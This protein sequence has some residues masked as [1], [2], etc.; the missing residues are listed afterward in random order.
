[1][2]RKT[3]T[4]LTSKGEEILVDEFNYEHL[5]KFTWAVDSKGYVRSSSN[6][7]KGIIGVIKMHR[8]I[9][10][11]YDKSYQVDHIN[12]NKLDNRV[13]NL[14]VCTNYENSLNRGI[15]K[16]HSTGFKGVKKHGIKNKPYQSRIK[17]YGKE[18][19]LGYY[20]NP[21]IAARIYDVC[22][23]ILNGYGNFINNVDLKI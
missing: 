14:R 6:R 9:M 8:Y 18:V 5:N 1:M 11:V 13:C 2:T 17:A 12:R 7:K 23:I 21:K 3:K 16:S 19:S 4:I 20:S 15:N 10:G 22:S